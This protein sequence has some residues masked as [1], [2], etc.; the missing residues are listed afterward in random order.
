[1]GEVAVSLSFGGK[2]WLIIY[3]IT[4]AGLEWDPYYPLLRIYLDLPLYL[5]TADNGN[6]LLVPADIISLGGCASK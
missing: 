2:I 3:G 1:M 4:E 6:G 5:D